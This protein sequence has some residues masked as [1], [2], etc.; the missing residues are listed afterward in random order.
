MPED[1]S[2][3]SAL[4]ARAWDEAADGYERYFVPRFAPWVAAA[5]HAVAE[6]TLPPGPILVPCCGSFPELPVLAASHPGREIVGIDL[7]AGM[8]GLARERAAGWPQARVVEGDAA[9]LGQGW[10]GRC[11]GLVSVFGLQQLPDPK[12]ALAGWVA[13]LR[14][15]GR[16]SVMFWPSQVESEGPFALLDRVLAGHRQP[17]DAEWQLRLAEWVTAAGATV[18]HDKHPSFGMSHPDG[19]TFLAAMLTGGPLRALANARGDKFVHT[20]VQEFLDSAPTGPWH[21]EPRAR[22]IV[23]RRNGR[24]VAAKTVAPARNRL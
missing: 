8:V 18:E 13:A 5:V 21:H 14:P 17:S 7:S 16:L 6:V 22:W 10:L 2:E 9:A 24:D 19:A 15:G 23:G 11:A 20:L 12:A 3:S 4:L 1:G